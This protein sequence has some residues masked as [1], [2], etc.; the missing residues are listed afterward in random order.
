MKNNIKQVI[1]SGA[2]VQVPFK[3]S[4][5]NWI[6]Y[7]KIVKLENPEPKWIVETTTL[8]KYFDDIDESIDY[9]YDN[10]YTSKN[11]GLVINR[12]NDKK[13]INLDKLEE[14]DEFE[15]PSNELLLL[16]ENEKEYLDK[17]S[18]LAL[19]LENTKVDI[20]EEWLRNKTWGF[21]QNSFSG[22]DVTEILTEI[23]RLKHEGTL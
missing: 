10:A 23:R 21:E 8:T 12:L 4:L 1:L 15:N 14:D 20:L 2:S 6:T 19:S 7:I 5:D 16:I 13:L 17:E 18:K 3:S 9:F 11:I 22:V